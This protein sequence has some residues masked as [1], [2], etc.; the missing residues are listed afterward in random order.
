MI[1]AQTHIEITNT[2]ARPKRHNSIE[3]FRCSAVK[4]GEEAS[5]RTVY[6]GVCL[7]VSLCALLAPRTAPAEAAARANGP[8]VDRPWM[9][10]AASAE[11]RTR[12]LLQAMTQDE[13]LALVFGYF[14]NDAPWKSFKR[15][16]GGLEQSA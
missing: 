1:L 14:S 5:M 10:S 16:E 2:R 8:Q 3:R 4:R 13:K 6:L 12:M 11:V 9:N 7:F 15:P